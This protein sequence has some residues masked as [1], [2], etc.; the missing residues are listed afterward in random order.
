M[1]TKHIKEFTKWDLDRLAGFVRKYGR[2]RVV[3]EAKSVPLPAKRGRPRHDAEKQRDSK[4]FNENV[5]QALFE[6]MEEYRE[7]ERQ[8][9]EEH[10]APRERALNDLYA[11]LQ[12][13]R[14]SDDGQPVD[15]QHYDRWAQTA[16]RRRSKIRRGFEADLK[17]ERKLSASMAAHVDPNGGRTPAIRT[18][19]ER[20]NR[21]KYSRE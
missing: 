18:N 7:Q 16:L 1:T 17:R 9:D 20:L 15:R 21:Q 19:R 11:V 14:V 12:P 3:A 6:W 4:E 2:K 10:R 8:A 13:E 5:V